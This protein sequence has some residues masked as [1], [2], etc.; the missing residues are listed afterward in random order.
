MAARPASPYFVEGAPAPEGGVNTA[1]MYKTIGEGYTDA[2]RIPVLEGRALTRADRVDDAAVVVV[3]RAFAELLGGD[4]LG[5]GI[6]LGGTPTT[7]A[8]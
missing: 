5:K 4:A 2:L 7:C 8:W 6:K 1:V 3:N